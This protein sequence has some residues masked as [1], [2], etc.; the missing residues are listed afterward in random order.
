MSDTTHTSPS[1]NLNLLKFLFYVGSPFLG[2]VTM[3]FLVLHDAPP[4]DDRRANPPLPALTCRDGSA[5]T[6]ELPSG[7]TVEFVL[8]E[9]V[10]ARASTCNVRA[11]DVQVTPPPAWAVAT[12]TRLPVGPDA[13]CMTCRT[14]NLVFETPT[15]TREIELNVHQIATRRDLWLSSADAFDGATIT[16]L[17]NTHAHLQGAQSLERAD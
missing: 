12:I 1:R 5:G 16:V 6:V 4:A 8:T 13:C 9:A 14:W 2:L 11:Y 10:P 15:G 17:G 3:L 7:L